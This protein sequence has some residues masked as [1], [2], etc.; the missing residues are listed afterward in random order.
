MARKTTIYLVEI[1]EACDALRAFTEGMDLAAYRA[2]RLVRSAV[3]RELILIG[4]VIERISQIDPRV[5]QSLVMAGPI[6]QCYHY[7]LHPE[8][9]IHDDQ[10][11]ELARSPDLFSLRE[12]V[13][14]LLE[15][16]GDSAGE[17]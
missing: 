14:L 3:E 4:E 8:G 15:E 1:R 11:F 2:S 9:P 6:V 13:S 12:V 16:L 10:V 7:L 5:G 17:A